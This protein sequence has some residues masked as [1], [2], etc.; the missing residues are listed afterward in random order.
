MSNELRFKRKLM[1][2]THGCITIVVPRELAETW[3]NKADNVVF[4]VQGDSVRL[5]LVQ[6]E[7]VNRHE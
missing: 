4:I 6:R 7:G 1:R 2:Q 5:E 3:V